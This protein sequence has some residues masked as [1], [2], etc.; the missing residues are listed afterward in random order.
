MSTVDSGNGFGTRVFWTAVIPDDDVQVHFGD[1]TAEM[2]VQNL[3]VFNYF[4]PGGGAG[5]VSLGPNWQTAAV[6]ATVSFDVVWNG[7]VTR[8]VRVRDTTYGFAGHFLENQATVSWSAQ[9]SSGFSFSS[10]PGDFSTS[11]PEVPGV[12]GVTQ[13]LNFFAQIGHE[14]N[15]IFFPG[16]DDQNDQVAA[17]QD[18][19]FAALASQGQNSAVHPVSAGLSLASTDLA[20]RDALPPPAETTAV[21]HLVATQMSR[22][23]LR[24]QS[25]DWWS[26]QALSQDFLQD[27]DIFSLA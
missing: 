27:R 13:P 23:R 10:N 26:D 21:D 2:H 19:V 16:G 17:I 14:R 20:L 8:D 15:G 18:Q 6:D 11:L 22:P 25:L 24:P 4:A 1:G 3:A 12:N 9:S 5:N 7:P